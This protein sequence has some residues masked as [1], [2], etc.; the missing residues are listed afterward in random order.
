VRTQM[1]ARIHELHESEDPWQR[2]TLNVYL[3]RTG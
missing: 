3:T 1:G 2:I